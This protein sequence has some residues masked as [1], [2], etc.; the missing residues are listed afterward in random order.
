MNL[1]L[2]VLVD[3]KEKGKE[4]KKKKGNDKSVRSRWMCESS[5]FNK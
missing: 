1:G 5:L 3:F 4:E 2:I